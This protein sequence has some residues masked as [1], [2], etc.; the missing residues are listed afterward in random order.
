MK[1][2]LRWISVGWLGTVLCGEPNATEPPRVTLEEQAMVLRDWWVAGPF[3]AAGEVAGLETDF[4]RGFGSAETALTPGDFPG[5]AGFSGGRLGL[6]WRRIAEAEY[7]DF[8]LVFDRIASDGL[9]GLAGYAASVIQSGLEREAW[10]LLG[11]NAR[12]AV[13]LNGTLMLTVRE[14]RVLNQYDDA[15]RLPL[16]RGENLLLIKA[17]NAGQ[18]WTMTARLEPGTAAAARTALELSDRFFARALVASGEPLE[19]TVRAMPDGARIAAQ[20]EHFDGT[21]VRAVE[22]GPTAPVDTSG[23]PPG[24]YRLKVENAGPWARPVF[25]L[26][27]LAGLLM[28]MSARVGAVSRGG[29]DQTKINLKALVRRLEILRDAQKSNRARASDTDWAKQA[30]AED[31]EGKAVYAAAELEEALARIGRGEEPFRHRPGLHLRGFRSRIDDQGMYYRIFVPSSYRADGPGLPL[32]IMPQPVFSANRPFLESAFVARHREAERW[33][34][35]AERLGVGILWPG[36]RARPYGNP[37]D[38]AHFEEAL[39]AVRAD[40][41]VDPARIYL[42]GY[43]STGMFSAMEAL[44]HPGRYAAVALVN[45]VL[46]RGKG[47]FEERDDFRPGSEYRAWLRETDPL[48]RFASLADLPVH[49][50][51]DS[52]DPDHGPLAHTVEFIELARSQGRAP[53]FDYYRSVPPSRFRMMEQQLAWLAR[54][55]RMN[56]VEAL[57]PE[58]AEWDVSLAGVLADRFL[59]VRGTTGGERERAAAAR[60]CDAF[61]AAWQESVHVPCRVINDVDLTREDEAESDLVII[62]NPATNAVWSRLADRLD[63]KVAVDGVQVGGQAWVGDALAMQVWRPHP[64]QS[65]RKIVLIGAADLE[66]AGVGT[67]EL[68]VDGWF[69]FAVWRNTGSRIELFASGRHR[70]ATRPK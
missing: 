5:A 23:L 32:F 35:V 18:D 59:V 28:E 53:Q 65:G 54:Q 10:L 22:V 30:L 6:P 9:T 33:A 8:G 56:P 20:L 67:M 4:L 15:V 13:W 47:R 69:D 11:S 64:E 68:A 3:E 27:D 46:H 57:A 36:Y 24:P 50:F 45:P 17:L 62:G 61:A 55:R 34:R 7:V 49:V 58:A 12:L 40:Y 44:R 1:K 39:A 2:F 51:H 21:P 66:R 52:Y 31:Y 29:S 42:H 38:F 19:I 26:G 25:W 41:R 63:A 60:W 70:S 37:I 43:C 14:G 48:A 16:R